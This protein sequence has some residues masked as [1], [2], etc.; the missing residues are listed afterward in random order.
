MAMD[1]STRAIIGLYNIN[2]HKELRYAIEADPARPAMSNFVFSPRGTLYS[3]EVFERGINFY[4][5]K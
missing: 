5:W 3:L 1:D 2:S 4:S